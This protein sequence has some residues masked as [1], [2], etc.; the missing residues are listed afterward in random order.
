M[1]II[2]M[3]V[4]TKTINTSEDTSD[5]SEDVPGDNFPYIRGKWER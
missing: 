5:Y 2:Q 4:E 1:K 3:F